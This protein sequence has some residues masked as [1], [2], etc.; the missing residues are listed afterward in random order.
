MEKFTNTLNG[1]EDTKE[2][3]HGDDFELESACESRK[4]VILHGKIFRILKRNVK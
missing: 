1:K 4:R 2:M 3:E